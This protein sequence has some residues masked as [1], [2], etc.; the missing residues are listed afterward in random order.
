MAQHKPQTSSET[1][2]TDDHPRC[3]HCDRLMYMVRRSQHAGSGAGYELQTFACLCGES[4]ERR[5]D[6][7][8]NS[9]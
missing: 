7:A 2:G 3:A 6:N 9:R 5:V 8:G 4:F 1:A